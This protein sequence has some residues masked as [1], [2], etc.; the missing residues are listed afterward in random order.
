MTLACSLLRSRTVST[1]PADWHRFKRSGFPVEF[2]YPQVTPQGHAVEQF[3]EHVQDHRGDM[4]RVH[5]SSPKSGELY[6][7]VARFRELAPQDDYLSHKRYL[8]Q[9]FGSDSVSPLV[10]TAI[11]GRPAWAYSILAAE[12]ERSVLMLH[13]AGDTYR[14]IYDP[15]CELNHRVIDTLTI[16]G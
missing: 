13:V 10:E 7:E 3:E 14:F 5:L 2:S 1:G 9:R 12:H 6:L 15:R 8:A 11:E 16:E 4:E